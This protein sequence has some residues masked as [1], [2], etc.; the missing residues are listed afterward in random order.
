MT[1]RTI[2]TLMLAL[3]GLML[4]LPLFGTSTTPIEISQRTM[5]LSMDTVPTPICMFPIFPFD[6]LR[7]NGGILAS[8]PDVE[9]NQP[10]DKYE[11][12]HST[13]ATDFSTI[14]TL[15]SDEFSHLHQSPVNGKNYYRLKILAVSGYFEYS[16]IHLVEWDLSPGNIFPNIVNTEASIYIESPVEERGELEIYDMSGRL[17]YSESITLNENTTLI[18]L[19]F[20][21][22]N[23]GHYIATVSGE[24]L[25]IETI[26]TINLNL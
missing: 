8:W 17:I 20:T 2:Y 13:S 3:G 25:G 18:G 1:Q 15:D 6:V 19:D 4:T 14:A 16:N 23:T 26:L 7:N 21:S 5:E 24:Q 9:E 11:L 22:W 10:I 12:Q